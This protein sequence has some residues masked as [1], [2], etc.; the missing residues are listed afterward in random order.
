MPADEM[1]LPRRPLA[2]APPASDGAALDAARFQDFY[3]ATAARLRGYLRRVSGDASLA[4]DILQESYLRLLRARVPEG[5]DAAAAF[6][7]RIATNLLYDHFR[8]ARRERWF[9]GLFP[10]AAVATPADASLPQDLERL[11]LKLAPRE[12]ALLWLAHVEGWNHDEIARILELRPASVRVVLFRAR[13][14]LARVLARAGVGTEAL[15]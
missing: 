7:F 11:L 13:A 8:R 15:R 1:A 4:D 12:R 6:L 3:D 2:L 14:K 10:P 5:R 9:F